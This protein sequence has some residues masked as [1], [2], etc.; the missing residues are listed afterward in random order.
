MLWSVKA[1]VWIMHLLRSQVF[2]GQVVTGVN[3]SPLGGKLM[4]AALITCWVGA[5]TAGRLMA[6]INWFATWL[7][8]TWFSHLV[9]TSEWIIPASQVVH[10]FGLALLFGMAGMLDLRILGLG[11]GLCMREF[12]R[13][14]IPWAGMGFLLN[15]ITGFILFAGAPFMFAHNIAFGFKML[16][17]AIAGVNV[18]VFYM[19]GIA[20]QVEALG[21][22]DAAP[23]QARDCRNLLVPVGRGY[24]LGTYA[25]FYRQRVLT[26]GANL[27][28]DASH[29][30]LTVTK[31]SGSGT[32]RPF[33]Y[34]VGQRVF[35]RVE[36]E[37]NL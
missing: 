32:G 21:P 14:M 29:V 34:V 20:R 13:R 23:V 33:C 35:R 5:I 27:P 11:K 6:Y 17:I 10:F 8:D 31:L 26:P 9:S 1:A 4:A 12:S 28:F 2:H 18:L 25:A 24:V 3:P 16:F 15:L 36:M 19:T 22:G 37:G 7:K 30:H